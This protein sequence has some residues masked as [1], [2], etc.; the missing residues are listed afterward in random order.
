MFTPCEGGGRGERERRMG[1]APTTLHRLLSSLSPPPLS[2]CLYPCVGGRG[3]MAHPQ[4]HRGTHE[5]EHARCVWRRKGEGG[6]LSSCLSCLSCEH[7]RL[8]FTLP[9]LPSQSCPGNPHGH[10]PLHHEASHH[11]RPLACSS[12]ADFNMRGVWQL[13]PPTADR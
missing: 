7:S 5:R 6:G 4:Q 13:L 3:M 12:H 1:F 8:S 9:P 10:P 11:D 2:L